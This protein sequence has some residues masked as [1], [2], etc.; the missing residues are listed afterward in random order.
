MPTI[1]CDLIVGARPNFMK[2]AP[3][4]ERMRAKSAR[5]S[6]RLIHTGQHYD[7]QLSAL[8]FAQLRMP[9][10]DVNLGIGS[11]SQSV[12]TARIMTALEEA[13]VA[14]RPDLVVVFG[15]VNSTVA[16]ALV[17]AKLGI[18]TGHVEAGLRSFDRSMPEEINR[19][20][21]DALSDL[22]FITER[23]AAENLR[24][25]GVP[26]GIVHFAGN[27]M[28][29]TLLEHRPRARELAFARSLGLPEQGFII[30]T[31][32]RPSNVDHDDQ[33]R[34]IVAGLVDLGR[35]WPVL[36]PVH[37]RTAGR[38]KRT[39]LWAV[40]EAE[41]T[42][43]LVEPL[44]Y[45]EF[46][47]VM[48]SAAGIL[49]DSGG[50]QEESLVLGLPCVTLRTSTERPVSVQM[51]GNI[52]VGDDPAA[53]MAAVSRAAAST[54][55]AEGARPPLWDGHAADRIVAAIEEWDLLGRP[56][57]CDVPGRVVTEG[58]GTEPNGRGC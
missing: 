10:P 35:R 21:T 31:L 11:G 43:R 45:L 57:R 25:E 6:I 2:A 41:R 8:L 9:A 34:R 33:L 53:G 27:T 37:P 48:D 12:Q 50:I 14:N 32:H 47:S 38:L 51:G 54:R 1:R 46:L 5:F 28:I 55:R 30:V 44:G 56:R 4:A 19:I 42:I 3:V 40:L 15:D 16:A 26:D 24:N 23:S 17:A 20:V 7:A 49:T 39:G 13:F 52:L 36:F 22:L 18:A 29:D 58:A